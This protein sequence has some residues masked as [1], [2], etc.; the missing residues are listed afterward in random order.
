MKITLDVRPVVSIKECSSIG[1]N[2]VMARVLGAEE[3]K[4]SRTLV[5]N[6]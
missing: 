5:I 6:Y 2:E 3:K 4:S 1:H